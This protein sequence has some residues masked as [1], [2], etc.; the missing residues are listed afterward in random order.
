MCAESFVDFTEVAKYPRHR[1]KI[2]LS[3][4]LG[5]TGQVIR[6]VN[7]ASVMEPFVYV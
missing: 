6:L 2:C 1:K 7:H 4:H 5:Y 3:T